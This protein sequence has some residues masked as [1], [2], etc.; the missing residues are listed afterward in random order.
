MDEK[1]SALEH[2]LVKAKEDGNRT[3]EKLMEVER[4]CLQLQ[5][6]LQRFFFSWS[7]SVIAFLLSDNLIFS[8]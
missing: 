3:M 7:H 8:K 2:E 5:Q 6:N 4:T 1:N